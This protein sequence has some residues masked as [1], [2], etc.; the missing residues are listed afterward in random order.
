MTDIEVHNLHPL[1]IKLLLNVKSG[2][3]FDAKIVQERCSF[4][5][6]HT[7]QSFSWCL[8]KGFIEKKS[9]STTVFYELT[10][11]GRECAEKGLVVERIFELVKKS[12]VALSSL[13]SLLGIEQSEAGSAFAILKKAGVVT[14]DSDK[15]IM[16]SGSV[17][18]PN[19]VVICRSLIDKAVVSPL[20]EEQLSDKE[21]EAIRTI[22]KKN[23][24]DDVFRIV[25]K[26]DIKY[27]LTSFGSEVQ[28]KIKLA[29]I[30]GDEIG[31]LSR[32]MLKSESW[33]GKVFR[34]YDVENAPVAKL[35]SGRFNPYSQFI[36]SVKDKLVSM[37]FEEFDGSLVESEF[38]NGDALFMPQFH[39]ARDIHDVYYIQS[40][41]Q[42]TSLE[43]K[44]VDK[45][46]QI[47]EN[48]G[49]TGS[50]GW[51]YKFDKDFTKRL[52]LRSQ[53]TVLSAHQLA[54]AKVPGKY[55]GV[56]RCFRYDQVDATHGA[57]FYQTEGIVLGEEANLKTLMGMLKIFATEF[58]GA[59]E[60][61][62]VP[63]YFPFT[64]PSVEVHI[65]HPKLGWFELGGSGIFRPEV[66]AAFGIKCPVLAWGIGI[67]RM[68]LMNLGLSDIRDL[69]AQNI[70]VVREM[71]G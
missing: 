12:A 68:A 5:S 36:S 55:F 23:K 34:R 16:L 4:T 14:L 24:S 6:G 9:E 35:L 8:Q 25:E 71:K 70:D 27:T 28:E 67:D 62:Y 49:S 64:E 17:E 42:S 66:T 30:T 39:P 43:D 58:A 59:E 54:T 1:E 29:N 56:V 44:Y 22:S 41:R 63:G 45:V 51:E 40:P 60:V 7:N 33:K 69:F 31:E 11:K 20:A 48:G 13:P 19:T 65:K 57:D 50:R 38:Y 2:E 3:V 46:A 15:N 61:K 47:H 52:L 18:L 21:K 53:G 26:V 10:D 32:D 37:G